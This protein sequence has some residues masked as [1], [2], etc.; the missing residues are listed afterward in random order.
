[1][2]KACRMNYIKRLLKVHF[3]IMMVIFHVQMKHGNTS[4]FSFIYLTPDVFCN[5]AAAF[6]KAKGL[7]PCFLHTVC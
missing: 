2:P 4:D 1:M 7:E 6:I 3:T 5:Q